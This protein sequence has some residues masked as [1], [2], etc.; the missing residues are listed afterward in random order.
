MDVVVFA[1]IQFAANITSH[2]LF[3]SISIALA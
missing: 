3:L 2:I 1:R